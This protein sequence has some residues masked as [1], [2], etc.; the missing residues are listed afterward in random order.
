MR[1]RPV[2]SVLKYWEP[3]TAGKK[4]GPREIES[5]GRL[6]RSAREEER[7]SGTGGAAGS[8]AGDS[9]LAGPRLRFLETMTAAR[10]ILKELRDI[11]KDPIEGLS[12]KA[13][14]EDLFTWNCTIAAASDSP[15]K[16]GKFH[17]T[18]VLPQ[19]FPFKPPTVTF[20]TKI[21]HPGINEEGSIC[22]PALREDWRPSM[23]LAS[24][25]S[26][27]QEKVNNPSPDDPFEPDIAAVLKNDKTKFL[28]T[29]KDWT[30]KYAREA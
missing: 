23:S 21:Y 20:T 13:K 5:W 18:L 30:K 15:Y 19:D 27:I 24:I 6:E 29:A 9:E 8:G 26:I 4:K 28:E 12:V 14:D 7:T 25:L 1:L 3:S 16:S 11:D 22:V 10:R 17:F 2:R